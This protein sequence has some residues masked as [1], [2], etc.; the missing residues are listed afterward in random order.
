MIPAQPASTGLRVRS[1]A[2][3]ASGE[4]GQ[5]HGSERNGRHMGGSSRIAACAWKVSSSP[6]PRAEAAS[7]VDPDRRGRVP[8]RPV[9]W[10]TGLLGRGVMPAFSRRH[11]RPSPSS[12]ARAASGSREARSRIWCHRARIA[13][14][15]NAASLRALASASP[16][17]RRIRHLR[18]IPPGTRFSHLARQRNCHNPLS[19]E[20]DADQGSVVRSRNLSGPIPRAPG[21]RLRRA[22]T[23]G[24]SPTAEDRSCWIRQRLP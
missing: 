9:R 21:Q 15:G 11:S 6:S 19:P 8:S 4:P 23:S 13:A 22:R 7:E 1:S 5:M 17:G 12:L 14:S 2:G 3:S 16:G 24:R 18:S 10:P 20:L